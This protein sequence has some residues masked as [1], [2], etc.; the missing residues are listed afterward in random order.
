[1]MLLTSNKRKSLLLESWDWGGAHLL[2]LLRRMPRWTWAVLAVGLNLLV[3]YAP[4]APSVA[5]GGLPVDKLV[6]MVVFAMPTVALARAGVPLRWAASVMAAHG[7]ISELV[8][9]NLLN[10]RSGDPFDVLADLAGVGIGVA[11]MSRSPQRDE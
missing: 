1:M 3:L 10:H 9:H 5:S 7:P 6:H 2:A 4:R 8:Q 11:I